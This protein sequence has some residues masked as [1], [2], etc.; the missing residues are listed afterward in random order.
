MGLL[1]LR[2]RT[3]Q[4]VGGEMMMGSIYGVAVIATHLFNIGCA[5]FNE[6]L[7]SAINPE[8]SSFKMIMEGVNEVDQGL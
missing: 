6:I 1:Y 8:D 5:G 4:K 2:G 3:I 7:G